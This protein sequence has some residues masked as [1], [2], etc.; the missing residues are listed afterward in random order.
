MSSVNSDTATANGSV[1]AQA[2]AGETINLT[3]TQPD[4]TTQQTTAVTDVN[5]NWANATFVVT[6][7]GNYSLV[8]EVDADAQYQSRRVRH[9]PSR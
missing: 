3:L 7:D 9:T 8:A 1:S 2:A 5:G 6:Q 4:G